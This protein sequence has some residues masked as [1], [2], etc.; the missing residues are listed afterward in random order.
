MYVQDSVEPVHSGSST[1]KV[2]SVLQPIQASEVSLQPLVQSDSHK[3][4]K[5][6]IYYYVRISDEIDLFQLY[7]IIKIKNKKNFSFEYYLK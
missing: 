3:S 5:H 7:K 1:H 2:Q 4:A 6:F